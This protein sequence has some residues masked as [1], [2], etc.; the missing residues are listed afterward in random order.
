MASY[1]E[2]SLDADD[3]MPMNKRPH[4]NAVNGG[5]RKVVSFSLQYLIQLPKADSQQYT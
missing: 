3:E 2:E 1:S 5:Q 4:R